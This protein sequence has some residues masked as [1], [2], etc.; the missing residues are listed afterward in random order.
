MHADAC[1]DLEADITALLDGEL[2]GDSAVRVEDHLRTC[3]ACSS[4]QADLGAVRRTL[5]V[6]DSEVPAVRVS[7]NFRSRTMRLIKDSASAPATETALR[8]VR[9]R[10]AAALWPVA[11]AA[12]AGVLGA[13]GTLSWLSPSSGAS[14]TAPVESA[15]RSEIDLAPPPTTADAWLARADTLLRAGRE[16]D[17]RGAVLAAWRAEPEHPGARRALRERLGFDPHS[18][19]RPALDVTHPAERF[20]EVAALAHDEP[21]R[22]FQVG[23]FRFDGPDAYAVFL[24]A[25]DRS[26]L[27][28]LEAAGRSAERDAVAREVVTVPSERPPAVDPGPLARALTGLVATREPLTSGNLTVFPLGPAEASPREDLRGSGE[29]DVMGLATALEARRI[30]M[31]EDLRR[32]GGGAARTDEGT[33]LVSL[34]SADGPPVLLLAGEILE[35]GRLHRMVARDTLVLPGSRDLPVPVVPVEFGRRAGGMT[36]SRFESAPGIAGAGLR[37]LT[38]ARAPREALDAALRRTLDGLQVTALHRSMADAYSERGPA[39]PALR[40]AERQVA[41]LITAFR[42]GR[43]TAFAVARG[44]EIMAVEVFAS[45]SHLAAAAPRLLQGYA[46]EGLLTGDGRRPPS[47]TVVQDLLRDVAAALPFS[48]EDGF[49]GG[50][51][52][53]LIAADGRLLATGVARG[54]RLIHGLVLTGAAVTSVGGRD[55][56]GDRP[57]APGETSPGAPDGTGGPDDDGPPSGT[58]SGDDDGSTRPGDEPP[59]PAGGPTE[60]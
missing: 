29:T 17:A 32:S 10:P 23:T 11:M 59:R 48:T 5:R 44:G 16:L 33:V 19:H 42:G 25:R 27:L 54:P 30:S 20:G 34:T 58:D 50:T 9:P 49:G 2:T 24:D 60:R 15:E 39:S 43:A 38:L 35:G 3:A 13:F 4:L 18:L 7:P 36:A 56:K 14:E 40:R 57:A 8:I 41:A 47:A 52:C 12:A 26:R 6:W 46:L 21:S 55:P 1:R 45:P 22:V 37:G 31:R 51:E 28:E 53:G